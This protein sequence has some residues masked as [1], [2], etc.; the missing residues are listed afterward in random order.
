[1]LEPGARLCDDYFDWA[2]PIVQRRLA[3]AAVRLSSMLNEIF[4]TGRHP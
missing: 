2:L 4:Q 1:M 3:Q